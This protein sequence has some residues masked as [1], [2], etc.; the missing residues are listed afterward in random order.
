MPIDS[1]TWTPDSWPLTPATKFV[2]PTT[3]LSSPFAHAWDRGEGKQPSTIALVAIER[4]AVAQLT[5][6]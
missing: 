1:C 5:F 2:G 3:R 6:P 4:R